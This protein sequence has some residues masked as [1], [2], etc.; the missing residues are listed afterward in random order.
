M[1]IRIDK[2]TDIDDGE[3]RAERGGRLC[4]FL[5]RLFSRALYGLRA[6]L[7]VFVIC[8]MTG[9]IP[10]RSSA[11]LPVDPA[12]PGVSLREIQDADHVADLNAILGLPVAQTAD[13]RL[14]LY[15]VWRHVAWVLGDEC[16]N[17]RYQ[18]VLVLVQSDSDS[19]VARR[20]VYACQVPEDEFCGVSRELTL[21]RM[22]NSFFGEDVDTNEVSTRETPVL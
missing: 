7:L 9:C 15:F 10:V 19:R 17:C 13:S 21:L 16:L 11:Y 8:L 20:E 6:G 12:R 1:P 2:Y 18:Q 22:A 4:A 3:K 14:S 5:L